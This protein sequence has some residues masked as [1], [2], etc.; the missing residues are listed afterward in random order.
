MS[1]PLRT[2][3][4]KSF[5]GRRTDPTPSQKAD[6]MSV[7]EGT[8]P[9]LT[10]EHIRKIVEGPRAISQTVDRGAIA[11]RTRCR[12]RK[13]AIGVQ[14]GIAEQHFLQVRIVSDKSELR[15]GAVETTE[16]EP[17]HF[18]INKRLGVSPS[19]L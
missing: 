14:R 9:A 5:Q 3:S 1:V 8:K 12:I 2:V 19:C 15:F 16:D 7:T 10:R 18:I 4:A 17:T 6:P 13:G 11:A